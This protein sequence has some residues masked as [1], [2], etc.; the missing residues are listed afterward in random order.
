[1]SISKVVVGGR[2]GGMHTAEYFIWQKSSAPRPCA[3]FFSFSFKAW[4]TQLTYTASF[5]VP[6]AQ[7][8]ESSKPE[9]LAKQAVRLDSWRWLWRNKHIHLKSRLRYSETVVPD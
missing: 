9:D 3:L 5:I 6:T 7:Q 8:I 4:L 1:M 2:E